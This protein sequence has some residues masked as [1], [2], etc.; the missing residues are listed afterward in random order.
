LTRPGKA[1][2]RKGKRTPLSTQGISS[3]VFKWVGNGARLFFGGGDTHATGHTGG[4]RMG[5]DVAM[6]NEKQNKP[7]LNGPPGGN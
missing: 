3:L 5:I 1:A 2:Q 4:H 7:A 6:T